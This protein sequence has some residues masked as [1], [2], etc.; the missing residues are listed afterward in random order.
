[1]F[2]HVVVATGLL[3]TLR[4]DNSDFSFDFTVHRNW[5]AF[6]NTLPVNQWYNFS[7]TAF[8]LDY[9][10]LFAWCEWILSQFA[11]I[12]DPEMLTMDEPLYN[13]Y[14]TKS[15]QYGSVVLL[16]LTMAWGIWIS[17]RALKLDE[18]SQVGLTVFILTNAGQYF[19]DYI[20]FH[21]SGFTIGIVLASFGYMLM[22]KFFKSAAL[23]VLVIN[24][25][26]TY[27]FISPA[28][29]IYLLTSYCDP[30]KQ[31]LRECAYN[32]SSLASIVI[33]GFA[34]AFAPFI[35]FGQL[36]QV[37]ERVFPFNR[38]LTHPPFYAPNLWTLYTLIDQLVGMA[39]KHFDSSYVI[40]QNGNM[41]NDNPAAFAI[42]P[43]VTP[44]I[45]NIITLGMLV[46]VQVKLWKSAKQPDQFLRASVLCS[47][48]CYLFGW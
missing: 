36:T 45:A 14:R 11:P 7:S 30:S 12:I 42:L 13:S 47:F 38:G 5:L 33:V 17:S 19:L 3:K 20:H 25:N 37:L 22:G 26:Q 41:W 46:P 32:L 18:R 48:T 39:V 29:F 16:D 9:M 2:V 23:F 1:M 28:Y 44:T 15:F 35:W 6:T 34:I 4:I 43:E 21:Y 8:P 40:Q 10:P 31:S 27:L 24:L